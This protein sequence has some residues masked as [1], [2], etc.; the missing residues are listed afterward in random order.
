MAHAEACLRLTRALPTLTP[1][2]SVA[3]AATGRRH[4]ESKQ[5]NKPITGTTYF[6]ALSKRA[7]LRRSVEVQRIGTGTG[8]RPIPLVIAGR[9]S[10]KKGRGVDARRASAEGVRK[11]L[12]ERDL[13]VDYKDGWKEVAVVDDLES[14]DDVS[15]KAVMIDNKGFVLI[16]QEDQ[17]YAI[18]ANCTSCKF[19]LMKGEVSLTDTAKGG[20]DPD[21]S[22]E[23]PLC[24]SKF[25]LVDGS[26]IEHCP[27]DGVLQWV[28]GTMK[29]KD[30]PKRAKVY[31]TH[32]SRAGRVYIQLSR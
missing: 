26:V 10:P 31:K 2:G 15:N 11:R 30:K 8:I 25:S 17:M 27:K 23:C 29:E 7:Q 32:V 12:E 5:T 24:H 22:I 14:D 18:D 28:I 21:L 3:E 9:K 4:S 13:N 1:C 20:S 6:G 19:P 16:Q